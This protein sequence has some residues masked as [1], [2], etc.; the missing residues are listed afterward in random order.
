MLSTIERK[1]K[2]NTTNE[3][4][5]SKVKQIFVHYDYIVKPRGLEVREVMASQYTV[6]MP[7]FIDL[8][9]RNTNVSFMFAEAAWIISGSNHLS[10]LT[11]YMKIYSN[12]SDDGIFL[13]GA[14][15]PKIV[16]QLS[17][18]VNTLQSDNDSRQAVINIWRE[19]PGSSK[20]IP[21]T[22]NMQFFIRKGMLNMVTTMRS[23]DIILGFT[24][25]VFT[26]SMVANAVRLLL[27]ERGIKTQLGKLFVTAG[28]MHIYETHYSK[29]DEWT[30]SY[31]RDPHIDY[32]V[33]DVMKATSYEDLIKRLKDGAES[34]K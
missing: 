14:Y 5:Q 13:A 27:L 8:I 23:Q 34:Y 17:Y 3:I 24:Y 15:G 26:F 28:S 10:R 2:M 12:F 21:C 25:D 29:V 19:R 1:P 9:S 33:G 16:D 22:T 31:E 7:A 30:K 18:V 11:P 4:W 20:D 32:A 6:G